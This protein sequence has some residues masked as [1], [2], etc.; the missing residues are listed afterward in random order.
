MGNVIAHE[1]GDADYEIVRAAVTNR[2]P[3]LLE[4][5]DALLQ[6]AG[7]APEASES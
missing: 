4:V 3:V 1:Y 7:P 6:E 5:L 2:I